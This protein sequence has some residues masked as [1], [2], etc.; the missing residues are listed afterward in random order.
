MQDF[1]S[2]QLRPPPSASIRSCDELPARERPLLTKKGGGRTTSG[3]N[4]RVTGGSTSHE[5]LLNYIVNKFFKL[6]LSCYSFPVYCATTSVH[7]ARRSLL[8][9]APPPPSGQQDSPQFSLRDFDKLLRMRAESL[10]Y[11]LMSEYSK[12]VQRFCIQTPPFSFAAT[13]HHA[14][15]LSTAKHASR[16]P[17]DSGA[18]V[19][20][21]TLTFIDVG[22][23]VCK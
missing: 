18:F 11:F 10:T 1:L 13:P 15:C 8:C 22:C 2:P 14:N 17:P 16:A 19:S 5:L 21:V 3:V 20:P 23:G 9:G 12:C 6:P 4:Y 7:T